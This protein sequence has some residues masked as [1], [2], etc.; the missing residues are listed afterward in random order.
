MK[1]FDTV[2]LGGGPA[3]YHAALL[4]KKKWRGCSCNRKEIHWRHLFA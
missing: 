3:G 2:I 4:L 1:K